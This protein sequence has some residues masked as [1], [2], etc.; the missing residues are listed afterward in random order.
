M[1]EIKNE[2]SE[3]YADNLEKGKIIDID[4]EDLI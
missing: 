4:F 1:N 3:K 2:R